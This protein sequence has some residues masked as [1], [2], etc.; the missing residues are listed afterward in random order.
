MSQ[1]QS[2]FEKR[3]RARLSRAAEVRDL[4]F[5]P[6]SIVGT[7][8]DGRPFKVSWE[9]IAE[10]DHGTRALV[11]SKFQENSG[12]T[13]E[14]LPYDVL[15]IL[16]LMRNDKR[17]RKGWIVLGGSAWDLN[18]LKFLKNELWSWFAD[19]EG[20]VQIISTE[21]ELNSCDFTEF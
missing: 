16:N 10:H 4:S 12:S 14:K 17:Y 8:P 15:K 9:I 6:N 19:S 3:L 20:K 13:Q 7:K 5:I 2:E 21:G 18:L 1:T 11:I